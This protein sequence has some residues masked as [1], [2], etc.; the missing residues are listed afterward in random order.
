MKSKALAKR[1][2]M[3]RICTG[4]SS[5]VREREDVVAHWSMRLR[6]GRML[7]LRRS[8]DKCEGERPARRQCIAGEV[9][10]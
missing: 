9:L 4:I 1:M 6:L 7:W 5:A 2:L 10:R 8:K 3:R